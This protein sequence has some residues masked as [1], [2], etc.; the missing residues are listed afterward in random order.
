MKTTHTKKTTSTKIQ[1]P[2]HI[3]LLGQVAS[4]KDTQAD[5]L[6][7]QYALSK[8]ESGKYWRALEKSDTPEGE[9]LRKTTSKGLPA[10]VSLMK[11]FLVLN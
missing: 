9:M 7:G 4:G 8:V 2:F 3:V 11:K 6:Y 1:L 5:L 10:P